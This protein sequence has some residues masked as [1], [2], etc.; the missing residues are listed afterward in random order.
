M[1]NKI[2]IINGP[3]LNLLGEREQSQ[4][5]STTFNQLKEN[6]LKES[7]K[8]GIEL[9]FTQ[10]NIEGELVNLIQDARKKYDGMIINAAGFTHTSVAIRDALDLFKKPIIELH[11]SNIY[12]REEFRHKSLISDIATGGIFGLGVEGYIL[13]IISIE[14][15]L[16]NENR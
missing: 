11:I 7:N 12:K 2:I 6:C 10:S 9:E 16:K 3:N 4:Y 14:K 8:I 1:N 15:I 5:G 13:A